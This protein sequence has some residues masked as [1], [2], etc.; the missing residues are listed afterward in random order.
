[1]NVLL[2]QMERAED[3]E[4]LGGLVGAPPEA[5]KGNPVLPSDAGEG[6]SV[7]PVPTMAGGEDPASAPKPM[8]EG[9]LEVVAEPAVEDPMAAVVPSQVAK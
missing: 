2:L 5:T 4:D 9:A 3:V 7:V 8:V 1:V 6:P